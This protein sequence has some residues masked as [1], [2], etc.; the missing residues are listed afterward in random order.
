MTG[1]YL[2]ASDYSALKASTRHLVLTVGGPSAAAN[3]TRGD[4]QSVSRYGS[5]NP[6]HDERFMP[7]DVVAD[8]ES[9]C[10]QPIVT[11]MLAEQAGFLLVPMPRAAGGLALQMITAKALKETSEVF[12]SLADSLGDGKVDT[13]EADKVCKDIDEAIAKLAALRLQVLAEV[14]TG[15]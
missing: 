7:I 3:I 1:R 15:E 10:E 4:H 12:V 8:L 2:P 6:E 13:A 14:E 11:R 5:A 9:E